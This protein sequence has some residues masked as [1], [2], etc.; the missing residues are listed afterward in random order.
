MQDPLYLLLNRPKLRLLAANLDTCSCPIQ[1]D[2]DT[3]SWEQDI[4][5][6]TFEKKKKRKKKEEKQK[7]SFPKSSF[8][9]L[10]D[11]NIN[12]NIKAKWIKKMVRNYHN[13]DNF[14]IYSTGNMR[15]WDDDDAVRMTTMAALWAVANEVAKRI[16]LRMLFQYFLQANNFRNWKKIVNANSL[17]SEV[18]T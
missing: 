6:H 18:G 9:K 15:F 17:D 2:V 14:L 7:I 5:L 3:I 11:L 12:T 16:K 13:V 10:Q 4:F 8:L 1:T